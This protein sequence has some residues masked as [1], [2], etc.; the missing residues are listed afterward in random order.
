MYFSKV[1][2]LQI[3]LFVRNDKLGSTVIF[4]TDFRTPKIK[5][6]PPCLFE[7]IISKSKDLRWSISVADWM[8]FLPFRNILN[9]KNIDLILLPRRYVEDTIS[10]EVALEKMNEAAYPVKSLS[11]CLNMLTDEAMKNLGTVGLKMESLDLI[12]NSRL[13]LL[14]LYKYL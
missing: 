11:I 10:S 14:L 7:R 1:V 2:S 3:P 13:N 5:K 8:K 12:Y 4:P 6:L 9:W